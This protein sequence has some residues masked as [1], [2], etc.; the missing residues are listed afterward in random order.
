MFTGNKCPQN[1]RALRPLVETVI[2]NTVHEAN[3]DV[4][5]DFM[6]RISCE[7]QLIRKA[8]GR[9][10]DKDWLSHDDILLS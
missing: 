9:W 1:V 7:K 2:Q 10:I 3:Y 4:D 5:N 6:F 8:L